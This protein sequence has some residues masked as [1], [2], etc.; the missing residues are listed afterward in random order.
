MKDKCAN[1]VW[2]M[3]SAPVDIRLADGIHGIS[4]ITS[5]ATRQVAVVVYRKNG[6]DHVA[7]LI[8]KA[9]RQ[10]DCGYPKTIKTSIDSEY[11]NNIVSEMFISLG[12]EQRFMNPCLGEDMPYV[13]RFFKKMG[14]EFNKILVDHICSKRV[15]FDV[16]ANELQACIDKWVSDSDS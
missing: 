15:L 9:V 7:G 5:I 8:G 16:T 12:I 14:K 13:E 4:C 2:E 11:K 10:F 3:D 6:Q 1:Q